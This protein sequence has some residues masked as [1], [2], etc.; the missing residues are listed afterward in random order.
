M[1][2]KFLKLFQPYN[3]HHHIIF[4]LQKVATKSLS[5]LKSRK[6]EIIDSLQDIVGKEATKKISVR[7]EERAN[8]SSISAMSSLKKVGTVAAVESVQQANQSVQP[9]HQKD[10]SLLSMD[11]DYS[12]WTSK[13]FT[14]F[15]NVENDANGNCN[16]EKN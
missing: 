7:T 11:Q 5:A 15:V 16:L 2:I 14:P 1:K 9:Q 4:L 6:E 3:Y 12:L 13:A 8:V 10:D